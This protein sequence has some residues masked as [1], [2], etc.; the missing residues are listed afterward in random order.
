MAKSNSQKQSNGYAL[1]FEAQHPE[2]ENLRQDVR[3]FPLSAPNGF[4]RSRE[5]GKVAQPDE[6]CQGKHNSMGGVEWI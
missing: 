4:L 1:D 5:R 2:G 6:G 3:R